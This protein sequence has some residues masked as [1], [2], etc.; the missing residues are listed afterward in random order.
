VLIRHT[1]QPY[2][3]TFPE[4]TI[5]DVVKAHQVLAEHLGID[6]IE[7]LLGGSLGGQ[8]ALEWSIIEPNRIK[9]LILI[10]T[11]ARHSPWGIAFNESQRRLLAPTLH[12]MIIRPKVVVKA[13]K[14]PVAWPCS[15]TVLT[16]LTQ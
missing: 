8:Q 16:K 2:Y 1:N 12:Y 4:Y 5:R 7:V 15:P 6:Q 3:L 10:A 11:N 14:P 13:L 9:N